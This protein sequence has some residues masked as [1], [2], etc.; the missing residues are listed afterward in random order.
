VSGSLYTAKCNGCEVP[1]LP[2]YTDSQALKGGT[3]LPSV[4]VGA[5]L[6]TASH[7]PDIVGSLNGYGKRNRFIS[8]LLQTINPFIGESQ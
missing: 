1:Y 7:S 6:S 2:L 8:P 5:S 4:R 3:L